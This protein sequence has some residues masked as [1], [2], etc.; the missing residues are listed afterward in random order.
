MELESELRGQVDDLVKEGW[1]LSKDAGK[2][3]PKE[4]VEAYLKRCEVIRETA[5]LQ[6]EAVS[7]NN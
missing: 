3:L 1:R 4:N 2:G 5:R 7:L 6:R